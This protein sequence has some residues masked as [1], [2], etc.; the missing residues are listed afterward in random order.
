MSGRAKHV[1]LVKNPDRLREHLADIEAEIART[2]E[3][4]K[5]LVSLRANLRLLLVAANAMTENT[6]AEAPV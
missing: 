6:S 2:E 5:V 3:L 4:L 1:P